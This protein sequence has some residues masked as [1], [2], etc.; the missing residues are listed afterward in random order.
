MLDFT[1]TPWADNLAAQSLIRNRIKSTQK[2]AN[3]YNVGLLRRVEE[4][5]GFVAADERSGEDT[6][7]D[8]QP[9]R[10]TDK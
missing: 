8:P 9:L 1:N 3:K 10:V 2:P 6:G 4:S 5:T 7:N